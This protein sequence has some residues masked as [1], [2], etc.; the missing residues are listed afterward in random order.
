MRAEGIIT[1]LIFEH[2]L[3]IRVKAETE[4]SL[5]STSSGPSTPT[6]SDTDSV[7]PPADDDGG[8]GNNSGELT[9]SGEVETLH[10]RDN[11]IRASSSSIK[12][13]VSSKKGKGKDTASS[14]VSKRGGSSS[15]ENLVGKINNLVTTDMN[16]ITEA[17]DFLLVL[18]YIPLQIILCI[19]FLYLVLGWR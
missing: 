4:A 11:T 17:R 3:R 16:N 7:S 13:S 1:Q 19:I 8:V 9:G 6:T 14:E 18:I 15:A 5:P 10:S 2:S 12:S